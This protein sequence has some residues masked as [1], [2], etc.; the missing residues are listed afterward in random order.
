MLITLLGVQLI[1]K[2][3]L[4]EDKLPYDTFLRPKNAMLK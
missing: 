1:R 2:V 4:E 3:T